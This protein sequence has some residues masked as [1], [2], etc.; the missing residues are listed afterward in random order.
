[1]TKK[2]ENKMAV[3]RP[4][5]A[6]AST[7]SS[8]ATSESNDS[9]IRWQFNPPPKYSSEWWQ[10]NIGESSF[11]HDVNFEPGA[12]NPEGWVVTWTFSPMSACRLPAYW[13]NPYPTATDALLWLRFHVLPQIVADPQGGTVPAELINRIDLARAG[14]DAVA[15]LNELKPM[16]VR[17]FPGTL[18]NPGIEITSIC[19]VH[20][21]LSTWGTPEEF[22]KCYRAEPITFADGRWSM[23]PLWWDRLLYDLSNNEGECLSVRNGH[24]KGRWP[25]PGRA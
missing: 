17:K 21:W 3:S 2:N 4:E 18:E 1:M 24:P 13:P 9:A 7:A 25:P 12:L 22:R 8:H 5:A 10:D 14:T 15:L 19:T 20:E 6:V 16:L 11:S 23:P